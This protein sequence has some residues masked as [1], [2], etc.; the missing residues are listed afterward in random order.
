MGS[1]PY[2]IADSVGI[3]K[4]RTF[5]RA[6]HD[7]AVHPNKQTNKQNKQANKQLNKQTNKQTNKKTNSESL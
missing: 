7:I 2:K 3:Q 1:L 4:W 5:L 6:H